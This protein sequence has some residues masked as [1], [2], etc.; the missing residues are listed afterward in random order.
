MTK[1]PFLWNGMGGVRQV[2]QEGG[3]EVDRRS[4]GGGNRLM[5]TEQSG[6]GACTSAF[7]RRFVP[8]MET[9]SSKPHINVVICSLQSPVSLKERLSSA[10]KR[11]FTEQLP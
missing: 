3:C 6:L 1:G 8:A 2:S 11:V 7:L 9:G 10:V 4:G 5:G